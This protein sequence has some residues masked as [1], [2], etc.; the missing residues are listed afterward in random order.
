MKNL[1]IQICLNRYTTESGIA[2]IVGKIIKNKK[3]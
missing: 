3:S 2:A 1:A